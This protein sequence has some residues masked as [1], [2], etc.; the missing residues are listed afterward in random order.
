M[1]VSVTPRAVVRVALAMSWL[2]S[3]AF[4]VGCR[5]EPNATQVMVTIDAERAIAG[6]IFDLDIE[7]KSGEGPLSGWT[8]RFSGS[9]TAGSGP[10]AWPLEVALTPRRGH[11]GHSYLVVVTARGASGGVVAQLRAIS[12]Y[13]PGQSLSL[14]MLFDA[15]CLARRELCNEQLTC[16]AG[17]CVD[18]RIPAAELPSGAGGKSPATGD[19]GEPQAV[20]AP[21]AGYVPVGDAGSRSPRDDCEHTASDCQP[22]PTPTVTDATECPDELCAGCPDGFARNGGEPGAVCMPVLT[23][24]GLSHG[25]LGPALNAMDTRYRIELPLL[26]SQLVFTPVVAEGVRIELNG[27]RVESGAAFAM[28]RLPL[29]ETT[30]VASLTDGVRSRTYTFTIVREGMQRAFVKASNTGA[31]DGFG[32]SLAASGDTFVV[33]A[34]REDSS[35]TG[36]DGDGED[37]AARNS[38]AVFV[39]IRDGASYAQQAYLKASTAA[40]GAHFGSSVAIDGDTV[41]VGAPDSGAG[42][43]YVFTRNGSVW[44][45]QAQLESSGP[46][47]GGLFGHS[48]ALVGD[49]LVVG[50]PGEHHGAT[51]AGAAYVFTRAGENWSAG[52]Q[53]R[54]PE[55]QTAGWFG[56]SAAFDGETL[57]IGATGE[58]HAAFSSGAAYVFTR[59][60]AGFGEQAMLL[61]EGAGPADFFGESIAVDADTVV[62]GAVGASLASVASGSAYVFTR[63][64]TS[65]SQQ[66]RLNASNPSENAHFGTRVALSGDLLIATTFDED[67]SARGVNGDSSGEPLDRSGAGYLFARQAGL[68]SQLAHLKAAEPGAGDRYGS[69]VALVGDTILIGAQSESSDGRG[70]D[71]DATNDAASGSGAVYVL[72]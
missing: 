11:S 64:G 18:P 9:L 56:T 47:D 4:A 42:A 38:G 59:T 51:S 20:P 17:A 30:L 6:R 71:G 21:D 36:V 28:R 8:E 1:S 23:A 32:F 50:A 7:V 60:A 70:V 19:A 41:A 55:P 65:W 3:T 49:V 22:A 40:A 69:S 61:A 16:S 14:P 57:A 62:V 44:Q 31:D 13:L 10:I 24:V 15:A 27:T 39:F 66:A 52:A 34:I 63:S 53:L 12:G 48:V 72:R 26:R 45:Q 25:E 68:W 35:A 33:G 5:H 67:S 43:V 37:N 58:T 2:A 54:S 46:R 29:G